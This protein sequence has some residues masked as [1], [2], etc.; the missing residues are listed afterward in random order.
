MF[1]TEAINEFKKKCQNALNEEEVRV[2][3][4]GF[5]DKIFDNL[6]IDVTKHN[7]FTL[8]KGGRVDSIYSNILFE[9]KAPNVFNSLKGKKEA[10]YGRNDN[11]R[12]LFH[13]LVN[14]SIENPKIDDEVFKGI[15]TKK[16]GV[17]FD[18][19][20]FIFCRFRESSDT[21]NIYNPKKTSSLPTNVNETQN[22]EFEI[23]CIDDFDIGVNRLLLYIRSTDRK[24]L[25]A[26]ELLKS[27]SSKSKLSKMYIPYLY[28]LLELNLNQNNRITTLFNEW[29]RI[30]G[31]IYG[32]KETDFTKFSDELIKMYEL[33]YNEINIKKM[34]FVLQTYYSIVTKLLIHN[35]LESLSSPSSKIKPFKT[36]SEV[37]ALFSGGLY[38]EYCVENFF[39]IHFFEWFTLAEDFDVAIIN[40]SS[41]N[42]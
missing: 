30:F 3:I 25:S 41:Q 35:L 9:L 10:I 31:E 36:H 4:N 1:E 13:Y 37:R 19:E 23:E 18:G 6:D 2:A 40:S 42:K 22:L 20:K 28:D 26:E 21:I 34:L 15:I 29:N 39:E 32:E 27:F 12:G 24:M 7:E 38:S 17:G 14:S 11:D 16:I 8:L 33:K 5:L